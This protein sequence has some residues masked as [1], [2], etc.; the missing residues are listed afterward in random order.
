MQAILNGVY[1]V[2][3]PL[4]SLALTS[5]PRTRHWKF[6]RRG[7]ADTKKRH[8]RSRSP[9]YPEEQRLEVCREMGISEQALA[10]HN[11]QQSQPPHELPKTF[12]S[13]IK[14]LSVGILKERSVVA[15]AFLLVGPLFTAALAFAVGR[16]GGLRWIVLLR[17]RRR[18]PGILFVMRCLRRW[19]RRLVLLRK[20]RCGL[21]GLLLLV[22][23]PIPVTFSTLTL[24]KK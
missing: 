15:V 14:T 13:A 24:S 1:G 12:A 23:L 3:T 20:R 18:A 22:F 5:S 19:L 6:E 17:R 4:R 16:V 9:L 7:R 2:N 21:L 8:K 10:E 11:D